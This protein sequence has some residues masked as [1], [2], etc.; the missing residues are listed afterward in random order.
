MGD[1]NGLTVTTH[2][3]NRSPSVEGPVLPLIGLGLVQDT[4]T[5]NKGTCM[6][7]FRPSVGTSWHALIYTHITKKK[8]SENW[9]ERQD[10]QHFS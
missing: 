2:K 5:N 10:L 6:S 3:P 1:K 7:I 4:T 8:K 9:Q